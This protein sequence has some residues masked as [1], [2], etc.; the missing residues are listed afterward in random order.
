[1]RYIASRYLES[2][3]E[4]SYRVYVTTT[5]RMIAMGVGRYPSVEWLDAVE[6]KP[7][8]DAVAITEDVIRNAGLVA[9]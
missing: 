7:P 9:R 8:V 5:M 1:M 3:I 4:K 6:P 2:E